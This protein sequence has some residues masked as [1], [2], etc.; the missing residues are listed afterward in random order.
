[1][2]DILDLVSLVIAFGC[3]GFVAAGLVIVALAEFSDD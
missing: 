3:L 2:N 1:M